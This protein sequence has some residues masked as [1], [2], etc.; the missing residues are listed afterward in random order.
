MKKGK[1]IKLKSK[2][3]KFD[4]NIFEAEKLPSE[5]LRSGEGLPSVEP[6]LGVKAQ[7]FA[8][9]WKGYIESLGM[10][11]EDDVDSSWMC[12][13]CDSPDISFY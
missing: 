1:T 13:Q 4:H 2:D 3:Q 7:C 10:E 5:L 6:T 12:P 11:D 9:G 8:C